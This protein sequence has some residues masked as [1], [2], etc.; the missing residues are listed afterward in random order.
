M[1]IKRVEEQCI[2]TYRLNGEIVGVILYKHPTPS[3]E[4]LKA[5]SKRIS[6][7]YKESIKI[8]TKQ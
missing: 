6:H 5:L 4:A 8:N 3:D 2:V 1:K 7:M